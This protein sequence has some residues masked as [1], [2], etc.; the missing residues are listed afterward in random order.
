MFGLILSYVL[1]VA[2]EHGSTL[3]EVSVARQLREALKCCK[4]NG[5][6]H[7]TVYQ[8]LA[9]HLENF[10]CFRCRKAKETESSWHKGKGWQVEPVQLWLE[11]DA[12]LGWVWCAAGGQAPKGQGGQRGYYH[13]I[14]EVYG[15]D[16]WSGTGGE[17]LVSVKF[18][19]GGPSWQGRH[20]P[21]CEVIQ[22]L[23][24]PRSINYSDNSI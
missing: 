13:K 6:E 20:I 23:E 14:W 4:I 10:L 8:A 9:W 1:W 21:C 18:L 3:P 7:I 5:M 17:G 12:F 19:P 2:K 24:F 15:Q 11:D 16:F 22:G